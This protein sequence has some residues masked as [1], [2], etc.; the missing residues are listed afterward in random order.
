MNSTLIDQIVEA[1]LYEGHLLYPYRPQSNRNRPEPCKLG[2]LYPDTYS[3]HHNG[4][5]PCLIQT[6][7]LVELA[8]KASLKASVRFLHPILRE[9][10]LLDEA[11]PVSILNAPP[12]E[13]VPEFTLGKGLLQSCEESVERR[14]ELPSFRL[15]VSSSVKYEIRFQFPQSVL[16]Q[17]IVRDETVIGF[18]R[19]RQEAITGTVEVSAVPAGPHLLKVAARVFNH[20]WVPPID[21]EE[22]EPVRLQ[23]L[24]STHTVLSVDG[25]EFVS[26]LAPMPQYRHAAK[27]CRNLGTWPVLVGDGRLRERD[28]MLSSPIVFCD[29]PKIAPEILERASYQ[30]GAGGIPASGAAMAC[31][32]EQIKIRRVGSIGALRPARSGCGIQRSTRQNGCRLR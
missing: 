31:A 23:T 2:C 8:E 20:T 24:S 7:C 30:T 11:P 4:A 15:R 32:G 28:T 27:S 10:E 16:M 19:R 3:R 13:C 17:P 5:Q 12:F 25:A 18:I 22:P 1:V 9:I 6:E 21:P 29:Y 14:V 26:L